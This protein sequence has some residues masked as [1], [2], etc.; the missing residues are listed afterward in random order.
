MYAIRSY[1]E[2]EGERD[3]GEAARDGDG[4]F[5]ADSLVAIVRA[6]GCVDPRKR[7]PRSDAERMIARRGQRAVTP[8]TGEGDPLRRG[9]LGA[10]VRNNFV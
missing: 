1:Y 5:H 4:P 6:I 2:G 3:A 9:P 10:E 7:V 8:V